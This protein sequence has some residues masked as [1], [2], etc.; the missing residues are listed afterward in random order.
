MKLEEYSTIREISGP[1][2]IVE[3]VKNVGYGEVVEVIV[4]D[5]ETRLGQV[6]ETS[7]DMAVIQV[8]EGTTGLDTHNTRVRFTGEPIKLPVS[9]DMLGRVFTGIGKPIDGP[10]IIPE[11][12]LDVNGSPINPYAREYPRDFIQTGISTIDGMNTL[13]RGQKLPIFSQLFHK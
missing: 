11:D 5:N 9:E 13:V 2:M 3:K 12:E 6:L 1:L 4:S 7:T 8:F 10:E